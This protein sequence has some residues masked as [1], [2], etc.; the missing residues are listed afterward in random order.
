MHDLEKKH[1]AKI[2]SISN[3]K[4]LRVSSS[5]ITQCHGNKKTD[6]FY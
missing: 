4:S 1:E 2:F 6:D 3:P 5:Y